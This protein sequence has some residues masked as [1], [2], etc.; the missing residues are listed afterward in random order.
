M[1]KNANVTVVNDQA[2]E[3]RDRETGE[4]VEL[5]SGD[6]IPP[7]PLE[8]AF[9]SLAEC[10]ETTEPICDMVNGEGVIVEPLAVEPLTVSKRKRNKTKSLAAIAIGYASQLQ[11]LDSKVNTLDKDG[12][13][14]VISKKSLRLASKSTKSNL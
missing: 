9:Q 1:L 8:N 14:P 12:F 10:D 7:V 4:L 13:S 11:A 3:S 6:F 5:E 2:G